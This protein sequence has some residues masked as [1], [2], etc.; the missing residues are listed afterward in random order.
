MVVRKCTQE[1]EHMIRKNIGSVFGHLE[2]DVKSPETLREDTKV[3]SQVD[4]SGAQ[5][6]QPGFRTG[7]C[8]SESMV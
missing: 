5:G 7:G 3:G 8:I 6:G 1:Q 4:K 2:L